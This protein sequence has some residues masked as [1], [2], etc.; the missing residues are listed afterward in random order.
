MRIGFDD[1]RR[2]QR[3][4][5]LLIFLFFFLMSLIG[6]VVGYF[7]NSLIVGLV[8]TTIIGI[9]YTLIV[10]KSGDKMIMGIN[11]AKPVTKQEYPHLYHTVEGLAIAA[12]LPTTPK[13][14]VIKDSA[15][16]A[17]ATGKDPEHASIAVT[18]GLLEKMNRQE[19]EGV[20]AHEMSHIKNHD[21]KVMMLAAVLVGAITLLSQFLLRMFLYGGGKGGKRDS[22]NAT[23]IFI[24]A[25]LVLAILS[26]IIAEMIKL[27]IS[28]K[29][30]YM[31]D[32]NGALLTRYP[33]GLASAL[34]KIKDDPDPLVDHANKAA[35]HLY[36]SVPFRNRKA[37]LFATH[38]PIE[39]R[40]R[41]LEQM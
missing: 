3:K 24:I 7:V 27:A 8:I 28:R 4:T 10:F 31:A 20:I 22:G 30:E 33:P 12:G 38:P 6:L 36:I 23:I 17:F 25:G 37:G 18:T 40:I 16:N 11:G 14:Y 2:N 32:A 15:L 13:C 26:P 21:I 29:R 5:W 19:L 9:I 1:I 35:A 39:E 34:R 41:R